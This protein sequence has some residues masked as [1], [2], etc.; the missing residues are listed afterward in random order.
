MINSKGIK[1]LSKRLADEMS[2]CEGNMIQ[3][4]FYLLKMN[5]YY[6]VD[7]F[8]NRIIERTTRSYSFAKHGWLSYDF[9][10]H[11]LYDLMAFKLK[12]IHIGLVEG[13]CEHNEENLNALIEAIAICERLANENY[14][15]KYHETHSAKWGEIDT[16]SIPE[17]DDK[18]KIK[19]YRWNTSRKNVITEEDKKIEKAEFLK[20][21]DLGEQ[22][23]IKDLD[24]LNVLF[25]E[26]LNSWWD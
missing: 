17:Y 21:F 19:W 18:G 20:C 1:Y 12:R 6:P 9:D 3:K 15:D 4:L 7:S 13:H 22:E 2:E 16:E 24:R 23:R 10:S 8:I 14:D 25:K 5:V 26:H 11:T